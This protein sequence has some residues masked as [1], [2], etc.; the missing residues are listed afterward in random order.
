MKINHL[1]YENERNFFA[2]SSDIKAM[3]RDS[4]NALI[5]G[6]R[7]LRYS[8]DYFEVSLDSYELIQYYLFDQEKIVDG[9]KYFRLVVMDNQRSLRNTIVRLPRLGVATH[10]LLGSKQVPYTGYVY[11][12]GWARHDEL[13]TPWPATRIKELDIYDY[14][15]KEKLPPNMTMEIN[16]RKYDL[17]DGTNKSNDIVLDVGMNIIKVKGWGDISIHFNK[18][19]MG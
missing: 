12:L 15:K 1:F 9:I 6:K 18:E 4:T 19:V 10:T 5:L 3:N 11:Y 17:Y 2:Y 13:G 16:N 8:Y 14:N 7:D